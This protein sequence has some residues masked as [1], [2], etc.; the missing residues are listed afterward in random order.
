MEDEIEVKIRIS[1][2][3]LEGVEEKLHE[4]GFLPLSESTFEDN[5]LFDFPDRTLEN[6]GCAL[7]LRNYGDNYTLTYKGPKKRDPLMKVRQEIETSVGSFDLTRSLLESIGLE[8]NFE[9][10][11]WR[12]KY[13][14]A[15]N[16]RSVEVCVD[17]TP[18]GVF[19]EIEGERES[20]SQI[21]DLLGWDSSDFIT[22][23]YVNLYREATKN[24][25]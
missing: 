16:N 13:Q 3:M 9:Y 4:I 8:V 20:I 19:V 24:G 11:K 25:A 10:A 23:N 15:W 2:A 21:A 6:S 18:V 17:K 14:G 5:L 22:D 1:E 12:Q 7:R